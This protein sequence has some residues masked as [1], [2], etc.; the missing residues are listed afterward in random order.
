MLYREG[1]CEPEGHKGRSRQKKG[2]KKGPEDD[3]QDDDDAAM[4]E[5]AGNA[6]NAKVGRSAALLA[7]L[8]AGTA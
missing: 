7:C 4:T 8:A 2:K 5:Q 3:S 6:I 1:A